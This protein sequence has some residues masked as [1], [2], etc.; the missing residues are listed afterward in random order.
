MKNNTLLTIISACLVSS[1]HA[2]S[3]QWG[4]AVAEPGN[5]SGV[6]SDS[7]V[8][9]LLWSETAFSGTAKTIQALEMNARADNGGSVIG[10]HSITGAEPVNGVFTA[11][12][13]AG[14]GA[15][16]DGY[17]AI[18]VADAGDLT[19]A[20]YY[21]M[22]SVSGTDE[23]TAGYPLLLNPGFDL[24]GDFLN[25][26]GYTV[27]VGGTPEP[28]PEPTTGILLVLGIAGLALKRKR[29]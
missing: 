27:A 14:D 7:S 24:S 4:G 21:D 10:V 12:W 2:A 19:K 3:L 15:N 29:A 20:S 22:G 18:L 6:I 1:V 13:D 26:N 23:K 8:A 9:V 28:V 5:P 16:V 11:Q 17:Y 25:M